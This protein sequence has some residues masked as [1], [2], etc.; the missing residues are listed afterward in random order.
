MSPITYY[1]GKEFETA[2]DG[3]CAIKDVMIVAAA[4][5]NN[6]LLAAAVAGKRIT[7]LSL[8]CRSAGVQ[9]SLTFK[10]ASG[11]ANK[12]SVEVPVNTA[13]T[14]NV[15]LEPKQIGWFRSNTGEGIYVDNPVAVLCVISMSYIEWT[16]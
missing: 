8:A 10:S 3:V 5:T 15:I 4:A 11:G 2:K 16:P 14:P 13:A 1:P 9:T 7:C 6:Q 12:F